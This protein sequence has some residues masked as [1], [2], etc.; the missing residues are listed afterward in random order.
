MLEPLMELIDQ[1]NA[2]PP[3]ILGSTLESAKQNWL[4]ETKSLVSY[5]KQG[6][7]AV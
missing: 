7:I 5:T 6:S 2:D 1:F 4:M 3:N